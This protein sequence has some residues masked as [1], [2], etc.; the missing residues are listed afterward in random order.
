MKKLVFI[1]FLND[2]EEE[3]KGGNHNLYRK[4]DSGDF[5]LIESIKPETGTLIIFSNHENAFHGVDQ[6][7]SLSQ[8]RHFIYGSFTQLGDW[9]NFKRNKKRVQ[10]TLYY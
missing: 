1:L 3:T 2:L 8:K 6:M 5:S 7:H 9:I 4:E 10:W